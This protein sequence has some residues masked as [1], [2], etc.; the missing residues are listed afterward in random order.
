MHICVFPSPAH[1]S[2]LLI[3]VASY[4]IHLFIICYPLKGSFSLQ[5]VGFDFTAAVATDGSVF[6]W[7]RNDKNQLGVQSA[8][9]PQVTR[10]LII[11]G[12]KGPRSIQIAADS[13]CIAVPTRLPSVTAFMPSGAS[14]MYSWL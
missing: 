10:K 1:I 9:S 3:S 8:P 7:G 4:C 6:V 5:F 14:C 12:P 11:K 13:P 2:L